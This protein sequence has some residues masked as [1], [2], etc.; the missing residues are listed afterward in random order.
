MS[1]QF[2]RENTAAKWF[3]GFTL[4]EPTPDYSLMCRVR[5]RI[6]TKRLST[7][8]SV[9]RKQLS[10]HGRMYRMYGQ[11]TAPALFAL[12]PSMAVVCRFCRSHCR[13]ARIGDE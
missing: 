6:G 7:L 11:I 8:F 5:K 13:G 2:L 3:C 4:S 10:Q 12:P 1:A 9:M